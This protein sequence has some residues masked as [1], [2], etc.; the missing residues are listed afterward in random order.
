MR[1]AYTGK[2]KALRAATVDARPLWFDRTGK[3][4]AVVAVSRWLLG[5]AV[6]VLLIACANVA[7]L[8]LARGITR[9]REIAVRLALGIDRGRLLRLLLAE[10]TLL[11]CAGGVTAIGLAYAGSRVM[12][13]TLLRDFAWPG[14][15]ID[16]RVLAFTALV[17][18]FT[19]V[20]VGLIPALRASRPNV[21]GAL[22]GSGRG[23][24][25]L[26]SRL[27]S[28]L[29]MAQ[30][31]LSV[32]LLVGAGLF[33]RSL[34]KI[35]NLDLGMQPDRVAV[36]SISWP[37]S[38]NGPPDDAERVRRKQIITRALDRAQR[39][40]GIQHAAIAVGTPFVSGFR[41]DLKVPGRDSIPTLPGGG[42]FVS[43]VT[44]GYFAT[45][46]TPLLRGR[47]FEPSEGETTE[48]VAIVNETMAKALWPS[49]DA[50]G[51]C[52]VAGDG[53]TR[54]SR[55]V[56]VVAD[57]RRFGLREKPAMQYYLPLGQES[58]FGGA[59]LLVRPVAEVPTVLE[60][61]RRILVEVAPD[62]L[63]ARVRTLHEEL[64]PQI[65]PWR[66]GATMFGIFGVVAMLVAAIG[67]YSVI[68]YAVTQ[69][70]HELGVRIALGAQAG[71]IVALVVRS[72]MTTTMIGLAIGIVGALAAGR[73]IESLL[74]ETS[75]RD[76][77]VL[78]GVVVM[79]GVV[80]IVA[81]LVPA[82]RAA[83]VDPM[84]ALRAE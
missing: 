62:L 42:P 76:P 45:V 70:R 33:V 41:V 21:T 69:R 18:L 26:R 52:I 43:A 17:A 66:L 71:N 8:L 68:A 49:D 19:G 24:V 61:L 64:D 39:T 80:S 65:R 12:Q 47:V 60:P 31:A 82:G 11:A 29:V 22:A 38:P 6:V 50:L 27:R 1:N 35:Q 16:A 48:R 77:V 7:N 34:W 79:L 59:N 46:G 54:C 55:V 44:S 13:S 73:W 58:G 15:A 3:P 14:A 10:S 84:N 83:R 53:E 9:R 51:K 75:A 81:T 72:G 28:T 4:S 30:A 36:A 63:F 23:G 32:I 25:P 74:F 40:P 67:L 56:G 37:A 78:A 20:M 5:V 57:A 2:D